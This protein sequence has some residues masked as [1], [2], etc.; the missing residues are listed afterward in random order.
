MKKTRIVILGGGFAGLRAA[1][2][3]DKRLARRTD[4]EVTLVSRENYTLYTPMLHEVASGDLYGGDIINPIRRILHHVHFVEADVRSIDCSSK[5]VHCTSGVENVEL[6]FE[7]DHLLLALGSETNFFDLP[8]VSDWA[9]TIKSL[10]DAL[11]LRNRFIALLEQASVRPDLETRKRMLTFVTA[12]GGFAGAETTG[13]MNDYVRDA[14]SLYPE[15]TEDMVRVVVVHP[16]DVLLPELGE[17]LGRYA[18][19]KLRER[20]VE[21]IKGAKVKSYDGATVVLDN[22]ME[23]PAQTLL[24]TAGV[25]PSPVVEPLPCKKEKGRV[26]VNEFLAVPNFPGMWAAGDS[27][28]VPDVKTGKLFP[29]TAQHGLREALQAAKNIEATILGKPLKPFVY[30]TQGQLATIG[31]HTG[32]AMIFGFK[33]SG[34]MAWWMWRTIYL[35]KLPRWPKKLRVMMD[36]TLDLLFGREFEQTITLRDVEALTQRLARLR[37]RLHA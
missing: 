19:K 35:A 5:T 21:V 13:A 12:G 11:L 36:W 15:L 34:F 18:E 8:G 30:K 20:K 24:W 27:A 26:L 23:I 1:M 22:G 2:H 28:A 3:F 29:P 9:V 33:F 31:R 37:S 14:L 32:V 6:P 16:S 7:Y 10:A 17:E 4:V 25:K